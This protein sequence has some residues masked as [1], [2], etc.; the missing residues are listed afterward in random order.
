MMFNSGV[1][2]FQPNTKCFTKL[3]AINIMIN[4]VT[5]KNANVPIKKHQTSIS[6]GKN[7]F[8]KIEYGLNREIKMISSTVVYRSVTYLKSFIEKICQT[9]P[10]TTT[11]VNC[12]PSIVI[13]RNESTSIRKSL[14]HVLLYT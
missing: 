10:K 14:Y 2:T 8:S 13:F 5:E 4:A 3:G 7:I 9:Y 12:L 11:Y 1:L 6:N